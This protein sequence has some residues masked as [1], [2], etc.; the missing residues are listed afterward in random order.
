MLNRVCSAAHWR[1]LFVAV[2]ALFA[3]LPLAGVT[4]AAAQISRV[5]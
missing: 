4:P 1:G 3:A 2:T 5:D